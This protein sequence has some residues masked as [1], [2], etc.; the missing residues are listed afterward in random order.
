MRASIL[1]FDADPANAPTWFLASM[2]HLFTTIAL[3]LFTPFS[4]IAETQPSKP[5]I[6]IVMP[7]DLAYGDYGCLGNPERTTGSQPSDKKDR[8]AQ[9]RKAKEQAKAKEL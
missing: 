7:D 3:V 1:R 4:A 8:A 6:I 9:R 2:K 5:N